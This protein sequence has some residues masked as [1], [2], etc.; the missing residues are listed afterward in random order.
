MS[1]VRL[2]RTVLRRR[3]GCLVYLVT[4]TVRV[5]ECR[6]S[7]MPSGYRREL[8][9]TEDFAAA[10]FCWRVYVTIR[11]VT[12]LSTVSCNEEIHIA[13]MFGKARLAPIKTVSVPRLELTAAKSFVSSSQCLTAPQSLWQVE[14]RRLL[15]HVSYR[16]C[17]MNLPFWVSKRTQKKTLPPLQTASRGYP[18]GTG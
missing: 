10:S 11:F 7:S 1:K 9:F 3:R 6:R 14:D 12:Y 8:C 15:F 17:Q 18:H 5:S 16:V 2:G 13:F 4:R